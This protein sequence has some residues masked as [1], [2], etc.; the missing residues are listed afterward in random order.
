MDAERWKTLSELLD[1]ALELAVDDR[2]AWIAALRQR[3]GEI[4]NEIEAMLRDADALRLDGYLE[5]GASFHTDAPSRGAADGERPVSDDA[6][7]GA[8]LAGRVIGAY[9]LERPLGRGGMGA[10]WLAHRSDGRYE[11][12][13][14]LKLLNAAL[15][16]R[17]AE[18]R[19]R[20]EGEVL[21]RIAHPHI[22]RLL[23][24]GV[25]PGGLPFLVLE[26]VDGER[27][28]HYCDARQMPIEARLRL[29]LDV[30][31]A[32][33]HAHANLI[34]HRDIKPEN[35]LVTRDGVVK[36]LDFGIA[37]LLDDE[38][39]PAA[40]ALT[41]EGGRVMTPEYAAPE[42][43][44][45]APV[46]TATDVYAL[47]VLLYALLVGR[48]PA[49]DTTRPPA[50]IIRS[51]VDVPPKRA[52]DA[53][54]PTR[55]RTL[56]EAGRSAARRGLA[57]KALRQRLKGDLDSIVAK[58]LDKDP[59]A[60]YASAAAFADD[61]RRHLAD[62]PVRARPDSFHYRGLRFVRR[63]RLAVALASLAVIA[64]LVGLVGT[65]VQARRATE[66][67]DFAL[68]EVSRQSAV[69]DL[70]RFLLFDA[71]PSGR[72]FTAGELLVRAE[73]VVAASA[74]GPARIDLLIA[75]GEDYVGLDDYSDARRLLGS[76][77]EASRDERDPALRAR[78][79][80]AW[81]EMIADQGERD[82]SMRMFTDALA[83]MP[84]QP[85]YGFDRAQCLAH[86]STAALRLGDAATGLRYAQQQQA[87]V[88]RL[89][90]SAP[91]LEESAWA[92]VAE[93]YR[94]AGDF[95]RADA[96]FTVAYRKLKSLGRGDTQ[97]AGTLLNNW[98]VAL[99]QMGEPLR[100]E[101][102]LR[103][104]IAVSRTGG[105][106]DGVS[107]ILLT[108]YARALHALGRNAE[109]MPYSDRAC[110]MARSEGDVVA[111]NLALV[112]RATIRRSLGDVDGAEQALNE[113]EPRLRAALPPG[114][115]AFASIASERAMLAWAR[116]DTATAMTLADRAVEIAVRDP[117]GGYATP[118]LLN[119]RARLELDLGRYAAAE[120]DASRALSLEAPMLASGR[121][122]LVPGHSYLAL[123]EALRAQGKTS[124]ARRAFASAL[125]QLR[126]AAGPEHP[127]SLRAERLAAA[128]DPP[129]P[130]RR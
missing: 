88:A 121:P 19:F 84:D 37:K 31:A 123:G 2:T 40:T 63:N 55:V 120:A 112:Q 28:D 76:A 68:R 108:N 39:E 18:R 90:F 53:V 113:V 50:E 124:E 115:F 6:A 78:A 61:I 38:G 91:T 94:V 87:A 129:G 65:I 101:P 95:V 80:C 93:S 56:E 130:D 32:V 66:E 5:H 99:V 75:I 81:A 104:A 49:G 62:L 12:R 21:A 54:S 107:P 127:D 10:V 114:H 83:Q 74:A 3:D 9:T 44:T 125:A 97:E 1:R 71:A 22:T 24:A 41:R 116:H 36:L 98:G 27:I 109:A 23:D 11:G 47:G 51:I 106:D 110:A 42:Q 72:A 8:P 122:S 117:H 14:A 57:P 48:H 64:T 89:P 79:E 118:T 82:R 73:H 43:L 35:V 85:R 17:A 119:R 100:A 33:E 59:A 4:A 96:A 46:T 13:V 86:A 105:S 34:V 15:I 102:M 25:A 45:G 7:A 58:A 26:L 92:A 20:R 69:S 77:F 70:D 103:R 111:T 52:S 29:F 30:L 128:G 16:G 60:R 126:P 67:R